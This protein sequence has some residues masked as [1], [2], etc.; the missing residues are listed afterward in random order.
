MDIQS[1]LG[2]VMQWHRDGQFEPIVN[3]VSSGRRFPVGAAK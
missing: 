2:Q 3:L 1:V